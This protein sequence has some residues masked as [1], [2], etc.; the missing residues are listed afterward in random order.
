MTSAF[1]RENL[2]LRMR[3]LVPAAVLTLLPSSALA[4]YSVAATDST[5]GDDLRATRIDRGA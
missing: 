1:V 5:L 4:T 2:H 3:F